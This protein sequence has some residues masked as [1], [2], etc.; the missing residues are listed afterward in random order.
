MK[1]PTTFMPP[2][3]RI[4]PRAEYEQAIARAF[5]GRRRPWY[6][7]VFGFLPRDFVV[8]DVATILEGAQWNTDLMAHTY[9]HLIGLKHEPW[10]S[11]DVMSPTPPRLHDAHD[12]RRRAAAWTRTS[13]QAGGGRG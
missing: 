1:S 7:R 13:R 3:A 6:W 11:F 8:G 9:G 12:L 5:E 4:L 10:W 2:P